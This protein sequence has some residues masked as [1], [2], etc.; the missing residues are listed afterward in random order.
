MVVRE[1]N[2]MPTKPISVV[3][4]DDKKEDRFLLKQAIARHAAHL[5]V[6]GEVENGL[7]LI[8]YPSGKNEY[9]DRGK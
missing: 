1:I 7:Q 2:P 5:R 6:A 8:D 3:I 9:A 4:A